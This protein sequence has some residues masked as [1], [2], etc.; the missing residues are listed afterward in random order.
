MDWLRA[1]K[2]LHA[3]RRP[4]VL[5]MPAAVH[6]QAARQAGAEMVSSAERDWDAVAGA[7]SR[8]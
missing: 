6:G 5:G 1:V 3:E 4:G 8:P 2:G 7:T